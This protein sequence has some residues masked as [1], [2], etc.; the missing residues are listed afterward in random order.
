[1]R[2]I[3]LRKRIYRISEDKFDD[4]KPN[5]EF[6]TEQIDETCFVNDTFSGS[7]FFK[8]TNDV[9]IRGIVYCDNP[10]I[11]LSDP[12][13]DSVNVRI[14]YSIDDFNFKAGEA[15][16]GN[17]IIV[18]VG[19]EKYIPFSIQYVKRP[20]TCSMGEIHS[21]QEYADFAQSRFAEAVSLFYSDRFSEFIEDSWRRTV[22]TKNCPLLLVL[23]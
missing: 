23:Y 8:S 12:W 18:A 5:I 7:I 15:I 11:T 13:F 3:V 1:M 9:K 20:L 16:K 22:C 2:R 19:V 10:Y 6:D 21:L 17:F 14:D 4:L